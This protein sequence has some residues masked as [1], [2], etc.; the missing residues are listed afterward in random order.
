MSESERPPGARPPAPPPLDLV[1][2]FVNTRAI[3]EDDP[4]AREDL[5][6]PAAFDAWWRA[7]RPDDPPLRTTR[8]DLDEA[9]AVREGLRALLAR[10]NDAGRDA[11][12]AAIA[13]LEDI[14]ATLPLR[15][16]LGDE[17]VVPFAARPAR[18]ALATLLARTVQARADGSWPRLKACR[19][20]YCR[21]AFYDTSKNHSATWCSM[22]VCGTRAKHRAFIIRRR[23]R[24][25]PSSP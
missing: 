21:E 11:D 25:R 7:R 19:N 20:S 3:T 23:E 24:S 4:F 10:N 17:L 18:A 5:A 15:A 22:A 2:A 6:S 13:R 1:Q 16:G 14:A 12:A 9:I 8:R